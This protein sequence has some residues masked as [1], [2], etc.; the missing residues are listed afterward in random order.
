MGRPHDDTALHRIAYFGDRTENANKPAGRIA[1]CNGCSPRSVFLLC[2]C[3]IYFWVSGW[4]FVTACFTF[5]ALLCVRRDSFFL[6]V[7][8]FIHGCAVA[9]FQAVATC[10]AIIGDFAFCRAGFLTDFFTGFIKFPIGAF[11]FF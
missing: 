1:I 11:E 4:L 8:V 6:S 2:L 3:L 10:F 9:R 7:A 5:G